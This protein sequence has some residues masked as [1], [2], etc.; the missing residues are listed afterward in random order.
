MSSSEAHSTRRIPVSALC[1]RSP[2]T[3]TAEWLAVMLPPGER[4][5]PRGAAHTIQYPRSCVEEPVVEARLALLEPHLFERRRPRIRVNEHERG[6]LHAR[7]D[8]AR[9]DVVVDRR[10]AH[11][12]VELLLNLREHRRA[13]LLVQ[14]LR[15]LA[16]E[17]LDVGI[18]AVRVRAL[19][20]HG[21][22]QARAGVAVDGVDAH[23]DSL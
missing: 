17:R 1:R 14:L 2:I 19:G 3:Q 22:R 18:G 5:G 21:L 4:D 6:V 9:P 23:A 15:L 13:L 12:V 11:A 16:V 7:T 10:E 8:P 20:R